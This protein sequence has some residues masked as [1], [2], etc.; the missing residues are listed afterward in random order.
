MIAV[1]L[2]YQIANDS[3]QINLCSICRDI[4]L[5]ICVN[6]DLAL[7]ADWT[8]ST[9]YLNSPCLYIINQTITLNQINNTFNPTQME[10]NR[11]SDSSRG[12]FS[13]FVNL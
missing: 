10:Q 11:Y 7:A 3:H 1:Y 5:K 12:I 4:Q 8:S 6:P 9:D 13:E 2:E